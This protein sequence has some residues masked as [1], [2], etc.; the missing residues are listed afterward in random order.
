MSCGQMQRISVLALLSDPLGRFPGLIPER[1]GWNL[2]H[3][4]LGTG[5]CWELPGEF[6][7]AAGAGN[8][9]LIH[10]SGRPTC[11]LKSVRNE[12]NQ[13]SHLTTKNLNKFIWCHTEIE[14]QRADETSA[15]FF[16]ST[17]E[18]LVG[19]VMMAA[20]LVLVHVQL[21]LGKLLLAKDKAGFVPGLL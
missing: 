16:S 4:G 17:E 11:W 5:I 1:L 9:H 14:S 8:K 15:G 3:G 10:R 21:Y 7:C 20:P 12:I 13:V 6:G 2:W 18:I 19:L